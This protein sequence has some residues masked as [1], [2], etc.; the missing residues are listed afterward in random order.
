MFFDREWPRV[1]G[2]AKYLHLGHEHR[3]EATK[4]E[5]QQLRDNLCDHERRNMGRGE[6]MVLT[7][8]TVTPGRRKK[9]NWFIPGRMIA[10]ISPM[11]HARIVFTGMSGSSVLATAD[12]TSG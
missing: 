11:V 7:P 3:P 5:G 1:E 10:H 12:R 9:K 8:V 4:R 2:Q 6:D